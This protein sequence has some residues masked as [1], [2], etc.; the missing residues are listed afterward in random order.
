MVLFTGL[1]ATSGYFIAQNR[2]AADEAGSMY[3]ELAD[4]VE[5][6]KTP[7]VDENGLYVGFVS[8]SK[9]FNS[10]R[11]VLVHYSQD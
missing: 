6:N 2:K 10:Y 11:R 5:K 4:M 9:I 3:D 1:L 8:K 7:V